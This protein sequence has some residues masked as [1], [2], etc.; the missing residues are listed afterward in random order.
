MS[1]HL[2]DE[3]L[4]DVTHRVKPSAQARALERMGVPF[5]RRPD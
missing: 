5:K 2:A 1:Q 3:E 4:Y